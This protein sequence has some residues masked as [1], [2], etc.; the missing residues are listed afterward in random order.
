MYIISTAYWSFVEKT[1]VMQ[2][3]I[4]KWAHKRQMDLLLIEH[5]STE[6]YYTWTVRSIQK[7]THT[8][9]RW[10]PVNWAQVYRT[11]LHQ[12]TPTNQAQVY[13]ALLHQDP[14]ANWAQVYRAVLHQDSMTYWEINT[15]PVQMAP[16]ANQAQVY[17]ALLHQ[18][19]P[20]NQAQVYR[21]L[22]PQDPTA[23]WA[24]VYRAVLHQ[25]SMSYWESD[26]YPGQ[27]DPPLIKHRSTEPYYTRTVWGI[28]KSTHTH[29]RRTPH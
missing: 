23:N 27:T 12:D 22:L 19:T 13:R 26:T 18:D 10:P 3:Q 9:D 28:D 1:S 17:R 16:P 15:Y 8:Q 4:Q 14:T 7:S 29:G 5:K 2:D 25:D 11:L 21:A 6:L 24:Q 20:T